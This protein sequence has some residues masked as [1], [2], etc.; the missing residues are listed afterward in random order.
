MANVVVLGTQWGDEGKGK[1]VDLLS[2]DAD[3]VVRYQGGHNAG[4][5]VVVG[6]EEFILHLIPSG[7]LHPGK[8]CVIGNGVVLDPEAFLDEA[9]ALLKRGVQIKGRLFIS[10]KSHLIMP[11]H[12]A[13]E[14]ESEEQKGGRKIGTTGRGIGPTYADKMSRIGIRV[15]DLY[16][17]DVFYHK[18]SQNLS[19]TNFSLEKLYK[20]SGFEVDQV[21]HAYRDYATRLREY[22]TDTSKLLHEAMVEGKNILLEGAQGTHLDVDHGTYPY[23]TSSNATAGGACTGTG[24]GP[25]CIDSVLGVAKAYTTRVGSGPFPTEIQGEEGERLSQKGREFGAT[26]GRLRRCGWFDALVVRYA[27]RINGLSG[28]A[29]TKLDVMDECEKIMIGVGYRYQDKLVEDIPSQLSVL[30]QCEPVYEELDGWL[31]PTTGIRSFEKLPA[32]AQA[33]LRRIEALTQCRVD[34]V[35]TGSG[36][37][38][39]IVLQNPFAHSRRSPQARFDRTAR[40]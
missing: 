18:L 39:T 3:F 31:Q 11:Y 17:G 16:D 8:K 24:M 1:I 22:V 4:H 5:T 6:Q 20:V 32:Q 2:E 30:E 19:E 9:D 10:E 14:K 15:A 36:R 25:T 33:Y 12:K 26:T 23:V 35:S 28:L 29:I 34:I 37:D 7:I 38:Q 21:N 27:V 40:V 13:I